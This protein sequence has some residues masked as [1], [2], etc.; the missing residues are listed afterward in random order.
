MP[1]T[2]ADA[3]TDPLGAVL[4]LIAAVES[5]LDTAVAAAVVSGV[6]PGRNVRRRLAQAL[7]ERPTILTDGRSPAPK[8]AG[9]LLIALRQ[10]G[11]VSISAAGRRRLWQ[12]AA[13]A[14]ASRPGLVLRYLR[15]PAATVRGL[16]EHAQDRCPRPSG[17]A[18]PL[19]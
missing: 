5:V 11:A 12:A 7:T 19:P 16:P 17:A 13:F 3:V 14:A 2:A 6:A 9:S 8:V 10:A 18:A 4:E 1:G 15:T